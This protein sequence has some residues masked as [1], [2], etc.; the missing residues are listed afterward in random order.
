MSVFY[1][2]CVWVRRAHRRSVAVICMKYKIRCNPMHPLHV[3]LP[4]PNV[5]VRIKCGALVAHRYTYE[6]PRC[7]TSQCRRTFIPLSVSLWNDL[8]DP[9]FD[10]VWLADES[11]A[12]IGQA[13]R[14]LFVVYCF[15]FL[16]FLSVG[17]YCGVLIFPL[18]G[19]KSFSPSL[20]SPTFSI[21]MII[22]IIIIIKWI[23]YQTELT[24]SQ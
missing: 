18:M 6:P 14:S 24:S 22:I 4:A 21:I 12:F 3:V 23:N 5:P 20:V 10:G 8:A 11:N 15:P 1:C 16:V 9:V 19:C 2:G 17:L 7:I 13:A